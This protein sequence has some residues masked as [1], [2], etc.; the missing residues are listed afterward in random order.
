MSFESGLQAGLQAS[1]HWNS[2]Q[3]SQ[4][5]RDL[6]KTREKRA[7]QQ[8][9]YNNNRT[10]RLDARRKRLEELNNFHKYGL[11]PDGTYTERGINMQKELANNQYMRTYYSE[12]SREQIEALQ[13]EN[14]ALN[15]KVQEQSDRVVTED[16]TKGIVALAQ[17]NF[18]DVESILKLN[19]EL[20][21]RLTQIGIQDISPID[22]KRDKALYENLPNFNLESIVDDTS[23]VQGATTAEEIATRL[24]EREV[25]LNALNSTF[26]KAKNRQGEWEI[27]STEELIHRSN[28]KKYMSTK[29]YSDIQKRMAKIGG[30]LKGIVISDAD[31]ELQAKQKE[32]QI[33]TI[34]MQLATITELLESGVPSSEILSKIKG[35]SQPKSLEDKK[36]EKEALDSISIKTA[37]AKEQAK[38]EVKNKLNSK[39][40]DIL[41]N[42]A[43]VAEEV[44]KKIESNIP[45]DKDT[46]KQ[47]LRV[48][49]VARRTLGAKADVTLN[50]DYRSGINTVSGVNSILKKID[51]LRDKGVKSRAEVALNKLLSVVNDPS[52]KSLEITELTTAVGNA[53]ALYIK[54]ISGAA[55]TDSERKALTKVMIGGNINSLQ[56]MKSALMEF[57]R[58][59]FRGLDN[60][61]EEYKRKNLLYTWSQQKENVQKQRNTFNAF[62][63]NVEDTTVS[64][65][66]SEDAPENSATIDLSAFNGDS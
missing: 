25:K 14:I 18:S 58:G 3:N 7:S 64:E 41:V 37:K 28:T 53:V 59:V 24:Q 21:D 65:R 35:G 51:A 49:K 12:I 9:K 29:S 39:D 6:A 66:L 30:I 54:S 36:L 10:D 27:H 57:S 23:L 45:I 32:L 62:S 26:F 46:K 60:T 40:N 38:I 31:L 33:K 5:N 1:S 22:W 47:L 50:K 4:T 55:V 34:D 56:S 42:G 52:N 8:Q 48:E 43:E 44:A 2:L 15:N 16:M 61:V 13:Q 20:R 63:L 11:N 17:G 19:P